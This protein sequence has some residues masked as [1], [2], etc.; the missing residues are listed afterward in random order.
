VLV[1]LVAGLVVLLLD[2]PASLDG[3]AALVSPAALAPDESE[4]EDEDR[5]VEPLRLSVL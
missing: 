2:D 4:D 5:L 1:V 3:V